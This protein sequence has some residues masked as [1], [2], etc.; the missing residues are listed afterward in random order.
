M[1]FATRPFVSEEPDDLGALTRRER[2]W[3]YPV[4]ADQGSPPNGFREL[5]LFPGVEISV[6]SGFHLL[7]IFDPSADAH[8]IEKLLGAVG[9]KGARGDS[10]DVTKKSPLEVVQAVLDAG[11]I[12]IPAHAD[13]PK[14]LLRV[15]PETQQLELDASAVR[16]V[17]EIEDLLA[18]EWLDPSLPIS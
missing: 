11:A 12:P 16:Q 2:S 5:T 4:E 13:G 10:D 14:G 7:A 3:L 15:K 8:T 6:S 1:W 9:Y 17:M 18:V